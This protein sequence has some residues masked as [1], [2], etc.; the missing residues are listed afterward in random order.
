MT[1]ETD[2]EDDT[3]PVDQSVIDEYTA[4]LDR[5]FDKTEETDPED[6]FRLKQGDIVSCIKLAQERHPLGVF[7]KSLDQLNIYYHS[8]GTLIIGPASTYQFVSRGSLHPSDAEPLLPHCPTEINP[9]TLA[10]FHMSKDAI[11]RHIGAPVVAKLRDFQQK[12]DDLFRRHA[13]AFT[14]AHALVAHPTETRLV[15]MD[16]VLSRL[17]GSIVMT[18]SNERENFRHVLTLR[19][20]ESGFGFQWTSRISTMHQAVTVISKERASSV[21]RAVQSIRAF[22]EEQARSSR[23]SIRPESTLALA[24]PF[25][26]FV[27]KA[28][29]LVE[30]SRKFRFTTPRGEVIGNAPRHFIASSGSDGC[31]H[32]LDFS[33]SDQDFIAFLMEYAVASS[34]YFHERY[35]A[36]P[37]VILRAIGMYEGCQLD[38]VMTTRLLIEMGVM[39]PFENPVAFDRACFPPSHKVTTAVEAIK[40][41]VDQGTDFFRA[42][43]MQ[44]S[45]KALRKDWR[46]LPILCIDSSTTRVRDDG[47]SIEDIP[48]SDGDIWLHVHVAHISAFLSTRHPFAEVARARNETF[49]G[50]DA[51]RNMLPLWVTD[52][53]SLGSGSPVMTTS[54]RLNRSAEVVDYCIRPGIA[55]NVRYIQGWQ[56]DKVLGSSRRTSPSTYALHTGSLHTTHSSNGNDSEQVSK[57]GEIVEG[58]GANSLESTLLPETTLQ[59]LPR[60]LRSLR[61]REQRQQRPLFENVPRSFSEVHTGRDDVSSVEAGHVPTHAVYDI[62]EPR[63]SYYPKQFDIEEAAAL[64]N[65]PREAHESIVT[66]AMRLAGECMAK[67]AAERRI[68]MPYVR[69]IQYDES[70][71][72]QAAQIKNKLEEMVKQRAAAGVVQVLVHTMGH[73]HYMTLSAEPSAWRSNGIEQY[74]KVTSPLRRFQDLVGLWQIDAILREEDRRGCSVAVGS[75][76]ESKNNG[77]LPFDEAGMQGE[78]RSIVLRQNYA[79][80]VRNSS[81]KHWTVLALARA[82]YSR[83]EVL[84]SQLTAHILIRG[85]QTCAGVLDELDILCST[86]GREDD[87]GTWCFPGDRWLVQIDSVSVKEKRVNVKLLKRL[88]VNRKTPSMQEQQKESRKLPGKR[89]YTGMVAS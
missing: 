80:R 72:K 18:N 68:P 30:Q 26:R 57:S 81:R 19:M 55:R 45:M 71:V 12:S 79:A 56:I 53:F 5:W 43:S 73:L 13:S 2:Q 3:N 27:R 59:L 75:S 7:L 23:D 22:Q 77:Y 21:H 37:C 24:L 28:Q 17:F 1:P 85:T 84:P 49:Y 67:W 82:L 36:L 83:P 9:E 34:L 87:E 42:A 40:S 47:I 31:I 65:V 70:T 20:L 46:D 38:A 62:N 41:K 60:L 15:T 89:S 33:Q 32:S 50:P 4:E 86:V 61:Q 39:Q 25:K 66:E 10:S 48:D 44:D 14:N 63:I 51:A 52:H 78:I 74:A 54:I 29:K 6:T 58:D 64:R 69:V 88:F 8:S 76:D 35:K 11:P 16:E